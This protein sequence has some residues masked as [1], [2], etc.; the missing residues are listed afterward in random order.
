M[1]T[2][3]SKF[4]E[5]GRAF[6]QGPRV[7]DHVVWKIAQP[8]RIQGRLFDIPNMFFGPKS[9]AFPTSRRHVML[10]K[11]D[12]IE[13]GKLVNYGELGSHGPYSDTTLHAFT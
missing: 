2:A 3:Y 9:N 12:F 6:I 7:I 8:A 1:A 13:T 11:N 5:K 4:Q 10:V